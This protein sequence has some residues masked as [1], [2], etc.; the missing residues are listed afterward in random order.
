MEVGVAGGEFNGLG[1]AGDGHIPVAAVHGGV[2][3][4]D[5]LGDIAGGGHV[6]G[7]E[8]G[9]EAL[10]VGAAGE[11]AEE[12]FVLFGEGVAHF[13]GFFGAA[14]PSSMWPSWILM[15]AWRR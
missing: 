4:L 6:G 1:V 10:H 7:E 15:P 13:E 9:G 2:T 12:G 14:T 11:A 8:E 3:E 5:E